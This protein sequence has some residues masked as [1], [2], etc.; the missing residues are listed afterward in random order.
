MNLDKY[1]FRK[2]DRKNYNCTHFVCEVWQELKGFDLSG[3]L[4]G[5]LHDPDERHVL[6]NDLRAMRRLTAPESPCVAL[7]KAN[8]APPHVGIYINRRVLHIQERGVEY[9]PLEVV[10]FGFQS[11]RFYTC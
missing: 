2:Y 7:F 1:F 3:P 9:Q 10:K 5:F 8:R 4:A 11:V 6:L